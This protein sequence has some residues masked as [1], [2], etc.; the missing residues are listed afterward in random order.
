[1]SAY[2][3]SCLNLK[4]GCGKSTICLNLAACLSTQKNRTLVIDLDPQLSIS[5]WSKQSNDTA[6]TKGFNLSKHVVPIK[7]DVDRPALQFKNDLDKLITET[8]SSFVLIDTPPSLEDAALL[9]ALMSDLILIPVTPSP[10]DIWAAEVAVK[11]GQDARKERGGNL[12]YIALIPSRVQPKTVLGR[13]LTDSLAVLGERVGPSITLRVALVES[14]VVGQTI[15]Q[16]SP[17]SPSHLE[18]EALAK[19]VIKIL[20][21]SHNGK[22]S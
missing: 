11:T 20:K 7:L 16:Y 4:G 9:A 19:Y 14:A 8:N 17:K 22:K 3:I 2:I 1:M 10:L 13:E 21:G 6:K 18:F 12:P 15:D 5:R